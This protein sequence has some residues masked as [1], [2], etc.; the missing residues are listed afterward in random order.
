V[1]QRACH[2][3]VAVDPSKRGARRADGLGYAQAVLQQ[4]VPV[5]LV[6]VLGGRRQPVGAPQ[7]GVRS[8]HALQQLAQVRPAD[9]AEQ[10]T[11]LCLQLLG[12]VRRA[13]EQI[14]RRIAPGRGLAQAAQVDL[15]AEPGMNRVAPAHVY[16]F[17]RPRELL[18][19]AELFPDHRHDRPGAIAQL[20][21]QIVAA[22]T[23]LPALGLADQQHL[24]DLCTVL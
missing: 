14:L 9:G 7:L 23:P 17:A 3:D 5:G 24:V 16:R 21:A 19:L 13:I 20:Q 8:K 18:D 6:V 2:R 10:L 1:Q 22:V 15:R 12:G 4:A 11:Q